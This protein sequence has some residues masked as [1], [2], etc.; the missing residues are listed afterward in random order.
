M[1]RFCPFVGLFLLLGV[2][3]GFLTDPLCLGPWCVRE[4]GAGIESTWTRG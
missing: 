1:Q 3:A 4:Q 2:I